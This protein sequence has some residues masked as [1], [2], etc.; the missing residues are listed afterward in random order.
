VS[1][2]YDRLVAGVGSLLRAGDA[3][4][5]EQLILAQLATLPASPFHVAADLSFENGDLAKD[6]DRFFAR[7]EKRFPVGAVYTELNEF[8]T[9]TRDWYYT[10]FAYRE[11]GGRQSDDWLSEWDGESMSVRLLGMHKLQRAYAGKAGRDDAYAEA[12]RVAGLLVQARFWRLLSVAATLMRKVSVPLLVS[13]HDTGW[14]LELRPGRT[15]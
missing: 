6:F 11:Y 2:A 4:G 14:V 13:A 10:K 15:V 12:A 5:C 3:A 1:K 9:N 7:Q 8:Q